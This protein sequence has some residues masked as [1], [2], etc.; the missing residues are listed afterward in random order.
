MKK[1]A[2]VLMLL[3]ASLTGLTAGLT[4]TTTTGGEALLNLAL[5]GFCLLGTSAS[6]LVYQGEK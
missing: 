4:L 5:L 2:F 3:M 6:I 1:T